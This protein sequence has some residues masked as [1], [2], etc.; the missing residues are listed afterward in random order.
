LSQAWCQGRIIAN[1]DIPITNPKTIEK[2][3]RRREKMRN[4]QQN[5]KL[6]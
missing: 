4:Q 2:G 6:R 5:S 1:R 3:K